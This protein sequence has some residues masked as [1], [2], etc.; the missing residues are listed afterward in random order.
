ME[1]NQILCGDSYELIKQV[2]TDSVDLLCTDPPYGISFMGKHWDRA[3]PSV[4]FWAECL[5]VL[6]PGAFAFVMSLPRQDCL[7]RMCANL[8]QAGFNMAFTSIYWTF[9]SGFPKAANIGKLID[10]QAG[11][12]REVIGYSRQGTRSIFD[13]GKPRPATLPA[14][15][16][17]GAYAG[18]QP[19]P[20]VE[21]IL[22]AMK[23]LSESTYVAQAL[24]NGKGVTW[25][26][27]GRI[28]FVNGMDHAAAAAAARQHQQLRC[29]QGLQDLHHLTSLNVANYGDTRQGKT[30]ESEFE[31]MMQSQGRFPANV[32]C[33]DGILDQGKIVFANN[34]HSLAIRKNPSNS[35]HN[36]SGMGKAGAIHQRNEYGDYGDFSRYFDL[37][38]WFAERIKLL[39][40]AAQKTFPWLI[41]P[42]P[43]K[44]ER[45]AGGEIENHH[46][47]VKPLK[48]FSYLITL[49]SRPGDVVL[50]PFSGSGTT[51]IACQR[52]N[53]KFLCIEK[54]QEYWELS[55]ERLKNDAP[56][57]TLDVPGP[58]SPEEPQ[59]ELKL[60]A[61]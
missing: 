48:L 41:V 55:V 47:T 52:L 6:K 53:R 46:P 8:E 23:P 21:V 16:F 49:G 11:A 13:G 22:V 15:L 32:L 3:V 2:E 38:A 36:T 26:D 50:D 45:T 7:W 20:A 29:N 19:K 17:N 10:K 51:A 35:W 14:T 61:S 58:E 59:R 43:A 44:S 12:E 60:A 31:R 34:R 18:F 4:D 40:E 39:P 42:K 33:Q 28:P 30:P 56:Q 37:D 54:E 25:L 1:L 27:D 9:A 57:L 24:A 5:R